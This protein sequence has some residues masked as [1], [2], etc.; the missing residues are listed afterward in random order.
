M[1]GI[2]LPMRITIIYRKLQNLISETKRDK[3]KIQD[4]YLN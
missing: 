3:N 1:M 4:A 2:N